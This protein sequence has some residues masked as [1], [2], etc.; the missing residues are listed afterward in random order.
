M[1]L[2][3]TS[4]ELSVERELPSGGGRPTERV[5]LAAR[6]EGTTEDENPTVS[7]L[8]E[9]LAR[10]QR[11][12]DGASGPAE[13]AAT[14]RPDRELGELVD[15]YRPRQAEL[16]ALLR[17]EGELSAREAELLT[18]YL[19]RSGFAGLGSAATVAPE[20]RVPPY[21]VPPSP[22]PSHPPSSRPL[23]AAPLEGDRTP[24]IPRPVPELLTQYQIISLKQA[25]A[26]RARR[27]ISFEEYMALKRHFSSA[28]ANTA[29][30]PQ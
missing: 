29:T 10:L 14:P 28:E 4:L 22:P 6:F 5:R 24:A 25:G 11:E 2:K 13:V 27:Q 26:V 18:G 1:P 30:A 16:V 21:S 8:I 15:T 20:A 3:R 7:E 19:A 17:E 9:A 12:L 23:A